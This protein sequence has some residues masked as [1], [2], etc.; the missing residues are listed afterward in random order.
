MKRLLLSG[1]AALAVAAAATGASAADLP[2][3][4][5]PPPAPAPF[6]PVPVFTWTGF[7]LGVNAGYGFSTRS[8][9]NDDFSFSQTGF[10]RNVA[11]T[12]TPAVATTP[13]TVNG[14]TVV[15]AGTVVPGGSI[16]NLDPIVN[17]NTG[18]FGTDNNRNRRDGFVGGGQI[19]YN[20]QF[21]AGTGF[22]VGIEADI[23]YADFGRDKN[24]N[25]F[26][27]GLAGIPTAA[28]A[29]PASTYVFPAT[30][31]TFGNSLTGNRGIDYFG[32]V[33]ARVGYAFDRF[34]PYVTGGFAYGGGGR[35]ND[36][37]AFGN[38]FSTPVVGGTF[39]GVNRVDFVSP[40]IISNRRNND[41][42]FG[43]TVGGGLEYAFTNNFTVKLEALYVN[44]EDD[45]RDDNFSGT[46]TF[47]V[48]NPVGSPA[49]IN[50][51]PVNPT[52]LI[53]TSNRRQDGDFV[54]VRAGLN[55]KFN[56]GGY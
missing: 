18:F 33:R 27:L 22:V 36:D 38:F 49:V 28:F 1:V 32:T 30:G 53:A 50:P 26:N 35:N 13:L 46:Q 40:G 39:L 24:N 42:K 19:G 12:T 7:Y 10:G 17:G 16:V 54:V 23:Q 3:G 20:Y 2:Y 9:R 34:L 21:G 37:S 15:P 8:D 5:G 43:Y 51:L 25:N 47:F 52:T 14:G 29:L 4:K 48:T 56:F 41:T 11:V 45:R 44:L 6:I 55:Y 31:S